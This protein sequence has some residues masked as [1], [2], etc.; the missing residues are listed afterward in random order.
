MDDRTVKHLEF[1]Q[2]AIVRMN[3]NSFQIKKI[4]IT[5]IAALLALYASSNNFV[6][7]FIA[8]VPTIIFWCLDA[9]YLQQER[10][11]RGVYDD[12]S[13]LTEIEA[14]I[15]VRLFEMPLHKYTS[16]KYSYWNA[17]WSSTTKPIYLFAI[18]FFLIFALTVLFSQYVTLCFI[19]ENRSVGE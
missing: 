18:I 12:V 9:Y 19:F 6:Y 5:I 3:T 15:I 2:N 13:E 10:K 14:R 16:E 17:L 1:I 7:L 4:A 8:I 11:F